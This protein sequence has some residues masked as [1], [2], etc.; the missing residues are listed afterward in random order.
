VSADIVVI[1]SAPK[2]KAILRSGARPG[3]RIYVTGALG[4]SAAT[5]ALIA[6]G[7]RLTPSVFPAHFHPMPRIDVGLAL[8]RNQIATAMIDV[9]DGLSTDLSHICEASGVGAEIW[10]SALPRAK[11]GK[12]SQPVKTE[13]V[14]HGGEDYELLFTARA[15]K[16]VPRAIAGVPVTCIGEITR[17]KKLFLRR[18]DGTWMALEPRGW[19]HFRNS[20]NP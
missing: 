17:R 13:Y 6:K 12:S 8:R 7:K 14:L 19:E 1:G 15:E 20:I 2:G 4:A 10:E 11:M 5:L 18:R 3:D 16:R 9:S